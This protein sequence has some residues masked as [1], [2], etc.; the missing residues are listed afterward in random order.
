MERIT[1]FTR[2]TKFSRFSRFT[3]FTRGIV[4]VTN[5]VERGQEKC[6]HYWP[7]DDSAVYGDVKVT[8]H[9]KLHFM[10]IIVDG[11]VEVL[12]ETHYDNWTR[13]S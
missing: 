5:L 9:F 7:M 1:R 12:E 3:G 4:M 11:Q 10:T 6:C 2:F 13:R 8:I